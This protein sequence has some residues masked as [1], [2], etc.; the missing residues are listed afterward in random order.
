[1]PKRAPRTP[2]AVEWTKARRRRRPAS[3]RATPPTF[4]GAVPRVVRG[5]VDVLDALVSPHPQ[6]RGAL[7]VVNVERD[8][9]RKSNYG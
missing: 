2:P 9:Q 5:P 7:D 6:A 4:P 8:G 3:R 1:M